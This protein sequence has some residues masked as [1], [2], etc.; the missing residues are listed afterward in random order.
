MN[1]L[2]FILTV[3]KIINRKKIVQKKNY[4]LIIIINNHWY[5]NSNL[6]NYNKYFIFE[7]KIKSENGK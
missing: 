7:S 1:C 3:P 4:K 5:I 6:Y 2:E